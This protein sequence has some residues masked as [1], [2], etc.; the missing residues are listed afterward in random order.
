MIASGINPDTNL[1]EIMEL[2]DHPWFVGTQF[3]PEYKSTVLNPHPLFVKFIKST[4]ENK[5]I[6]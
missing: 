4:I 6:K 1:V 3:H 5:K 2:K